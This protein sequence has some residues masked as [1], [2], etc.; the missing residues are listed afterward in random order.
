MQVVGKHGRAVVG[1]ENIASAHDEAGLV[2]LMQ[3]AGERLRPGQG[4]LDLGSVGA[5]GPGSGARVVGMRSR[6]LWDVHRRCLRPVG[7]R[8]GQG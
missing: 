5:S 7:V 1:I 4:G 8:R 6:V 2:A 3:I